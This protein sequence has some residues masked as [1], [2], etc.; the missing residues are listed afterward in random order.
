MKK[1]VRPKFQM[2][3]N[4]KRATDGKESNSKVEPQGRCMQKDVTNEHQTGKQ[5]LRAVHTATSNLFGVV[6]ENP[7]DMDVMCQAH[8]SHV[9]VPGQSRFLMSDISSLAVQAPSLAGKEG[10]KLIILDPPWENKS[11]QRQ[12]QYQTLPNWELL[13]LTMDTFMDKVCY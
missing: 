12:G 7:C 10:F 5:G 1:I 9:V 11:A 3:Y 8:D 6:H 4:K 13:D 2:P